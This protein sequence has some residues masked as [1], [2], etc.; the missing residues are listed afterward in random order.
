VRLGESASAWGK[1]E[2]IGRRQNQDRC[3]ASK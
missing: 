3:F 1:H 2:L